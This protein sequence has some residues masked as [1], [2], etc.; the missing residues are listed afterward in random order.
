MAVMSV[1]PTS[2]KRTVWQASGSEAKAIPLP[3]AVERLRVAARIALAGHE[4]VSLISCFEVERADQAVRAS[5]WKSG[6]RAKHHFAG[7]SSFKADRSAALF[8]WKS[9]VRLS[10][11]YHGDINGPWP[12]SIST[13]RR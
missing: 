9:A 4:D 3:R 2:E 8:P 7:V 12:S 1:Q 13:T 5:P 11:G 6:R 10:R